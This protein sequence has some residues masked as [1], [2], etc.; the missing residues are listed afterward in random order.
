MRFMGSKQNKIIMFLKLNP[1]DAPQFQ[2][3]ALAQKQLCRK[4]CFSGTRFLQMGPPPTRS[5]EIN[6]NDV[7]GF[8]F[9]QTVKNSFEKNYARSTGALNSNG[10]SVAVEDVFKDKQ[11]IKKK[12]IQRMST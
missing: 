12:K 3:V 9:F 11:E 1:S 10:S 7:C 6:D 2:V 8:F 5:H 4:R